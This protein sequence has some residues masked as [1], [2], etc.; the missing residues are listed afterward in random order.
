MKLFTLII[1]MYFFTASVFP[2][3]DVSNVIFSAHESHATEQTNGAS[4]DDCSSLCVCN[5]CG[6]VFETP[7]ESVVHN[8]PF[9]YSNRFTSTTLHPLTIERSSIWQPPRIF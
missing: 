8:V 7:L 9:I 3:A 1:S 5:C 4:D 2:C 6:I